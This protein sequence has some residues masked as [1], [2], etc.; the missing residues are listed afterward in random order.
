MGKEQQDFT[1]TFLDSPSSVGTLETRPE[2]NEDEIMDA[3]SR[4]LTRA[5]ELV[6]GHRCP[7]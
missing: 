1:F 4:A 7:I 3:Y 2:D 6:A 5:V